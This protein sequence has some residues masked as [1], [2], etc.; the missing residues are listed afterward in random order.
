MSPLKLE[1]ESPPPEEEE[2]QSEPEIKYQN[3]FVPPLP[4][5]S[6]KDPSKRMR[7]K[8]QNR[9]DEANG[10][11]NSLIG[12]MFGLMNSV[13]DMSEDSPPLMETV[14]GVAQSF[15]SMSD[16]IKTVNKKIENKKLRDVQ[17]FVSSTEMESINEENVAKFDPP[18]G[19]EARQNVQYEKLMQEDDK[20]PSLM[21]SIAKNAGPA[22][23]SAIANSAGDE[24][25]GGPSLL[26][27][28]FINVGPKIIADT[29]GSGSRSGSSD[30][31]GG[32]I[33]NALNL[34]TPLVKTVVASQ[35]DGNEADGEENT[36]VDSLM[37][38]V[39]G[40]APLI[41]GNNNDQGGSRSLGDTVQ[42]L[43][44]LLTFMGP[45]I[46]EKI[47]KSK[48]KDQ[49]APS[50]RRI[51][52]GNSRDIR[53]S[54]DAIPRAVEQEDG[55]GGDSRRTLLDKML[56]GMDEKTVGQVRI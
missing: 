38:L 33:G 9:E 49:I 54:V 34:L 14:L 50:E 6:K 5:V 1:E 13:K 21:S 20:K 24:G 47:F 8:Y 3:V 41:R 30:N 2:N 12:K 44:P 25:N 17:G 15:K 36:A 43:K 27:N 42:M 39:K 10:E 56:K 31:G 32:G 22:I 51:T 26:E 45:S 53:R 23:L 11:S 37:G 46:M 4:I 40:L 19:P 18:L 28:I 16:K 35:L 52:D 7:K 55:G 48:Q 29:F